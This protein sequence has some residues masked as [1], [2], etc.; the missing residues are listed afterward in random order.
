MERTIRLNHIELGC[1][2]L[3]W[4]HLAQIVSATDLHEHDN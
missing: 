2:G 3:D 4:I 1:K